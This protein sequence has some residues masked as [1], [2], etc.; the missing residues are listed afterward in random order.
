MAKQIQMSVGLS[1][2]NLIA[3]VMTVQFLLNSV[4]IS[5]GGPVEELVIDGI[6]GPKTNGAIGRFQR[7]QLGFF[8]GR[9]DPE[10]RGGKTIVALNRFD[11]TPGLPGPLPNL[12]KLPSVPF[13]KGKGK[14]KG[15]K[16]SGSP[17]FP[18]PFPIPGTPSRGGGKRGPGKKG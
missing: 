18:F 3:D 13:G 2:A 16:S 4:P 12:P 1:G 11:P 6:A 17:T 8:D 14:A 15:K 9:V 7:T 10:N 5:E